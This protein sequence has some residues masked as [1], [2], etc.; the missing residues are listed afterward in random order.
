MASRRSRIKVRPNIGLPKAPSVK[1]REE[2]DRPTDAEDAESEKKNG[3]QATKGP[4]TTNEE[5][6]PAHL[7]EDKPVI[8]TRCDKNDLDSKPKQMEKNVNA[9][10]HKNSGEKTAETKAETKPNS[11]V[12]RRTRIKPQVRL[13]VRGLPNNT[14]KNI[15][16]VGDDKANLSKETMPDGNISSDKAVSCHD[17]QG[18][19][20][21]S[22][23]SNNTD[24]VISVKPV[25]NVLPQ[26][27]SSKLQ[28]DDCSENSE[29]IN[30]Q[31]APLPEAV[32]KDVPKS[33][34]R[35][36]RFQKPKPNVAEAGRNRIR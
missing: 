22:T 7:A 26:N 12:N 9:V 25:E 18:K 17:V 31:P 6:C 34:F 5:N 36:S 33:P 29:V 1:Q 10:A 21:I 28:V 19:S 3:G 4:E 14:A 23:E 11:I 24:K 15:L 8:T 16:E 32:V 30:V 35:R 27:N 2:K 13:P 20:V